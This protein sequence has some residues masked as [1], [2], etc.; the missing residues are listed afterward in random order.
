MGEHR[1]RL[2]ERYP[3]GHLP[4]HRRPPGARGHDLRR[5]RPQRIDLPHLPQPPDGLAGPGPG[6]RPARWIL[7]LRARRHGR[8]ARGRPPASPP[9][10]WHGG[11]RHLPGDRHLG[12]PRGRGG[13]GSR[14]LRVAGVAQCTV[15][16]RWPALGCRHRG[17]AARAPHVPPGLRPAA[18]GAPTG[19][20]PA[21]RVPVG[22]PAECPPG[23]AMGADLPRLPPPGELPVPRSCDT[24]DRALPPT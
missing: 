2:R 8:A 5:T 16:A 7:S 19:G 23:H 21:R 14:P 24:V 4:R 6:H 15:A 3:V 20:G 17:P 9:P 11:C 18:Q 1:G 12:P 22:H 13:A 10:V